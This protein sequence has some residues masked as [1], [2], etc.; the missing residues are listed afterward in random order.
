[1]GSRWV[2]GGEPG[3]F[4]MGSRWE[5]R[6]FQKHVGNLVDFRWEAGFR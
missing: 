4:Q 5:P 3:G 2:L 6:G 1:M